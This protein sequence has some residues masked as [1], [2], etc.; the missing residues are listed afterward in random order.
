MKTESKIR[1]P[2]EMQA[3]LQVKSTDRENRRFKGLAST[4]ELDQG[5]DIIHKGAFARTLDRWRSVKAKKPIYL[6]DQHGYDSTDR[7]RGVLD[8]AEETDEGLESE[9]VMAR[10][11]KGADSLALIEDGMVTGLSIGYEATKYEWEDRE[12]N[13]VKQRI[14]HLTEVKLHEISLVTFPMNDGARLDGLS[15]KSLLNAFRDGTLTDE[16]EA[17]IK[18]LPADLKDRFRAL[19]SDAEPAPAGLAPD[20]PQRLQMEALQRDIELSGLAGGMSSPAL[21]Q[22]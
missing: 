20:D 21:R 6:L 14:R 8:E 22:R 3:A 9:F 12:L 15:V 7:I 2:R 16:Q 17:A 18:G 11:T 19:L 13:G 1:S 4:W 10:T 5:G